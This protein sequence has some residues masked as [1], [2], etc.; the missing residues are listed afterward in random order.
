M[1]QNWKMY[2]V[3]YGTSLSKTNVRVKSMYVRTYMIT[4]FYDC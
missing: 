4:M 1:R 3:K 2:Q